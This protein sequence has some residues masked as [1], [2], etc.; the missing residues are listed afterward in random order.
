MNI[1]RP[2]NGT[3]MLL[4]LF[5]A[6]VLWL[7]VNYDRES[8][9]ELMIPVQIINLPPGLVI[10]GQAPARLNVRIA[11]PRIQLMRMSS[12]RLA[13]SLDLKNTREGVVAFTELDKVVTA[14]RELRVTRVYPAV[15][16]VRLEKTEK[17]GEGSRR[18]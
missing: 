10:A 4:S 2:K 3:L 17:Y 12:N 18:K 13:A 16:E 1:R 15:I 11:G 14:P 7:Y 8:E 9:T 6:V 5:L